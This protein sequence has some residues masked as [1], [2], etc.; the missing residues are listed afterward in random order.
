MLL[1]PST[2]W[3]L[4]S[5]WCRRHY[6]TTPGRQRSSEQIPAAYSAIIVPHQTQTHNRRTK[7]HQE[8][9]SWLVLTAGK[10]MAMVVVDKEDYADKVLFLLADT[11]TYSIINKDPTTN[12]KRNLHRHLGATNEWDGSVTTATGKCIPLV[13]SP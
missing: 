10:G 11:S 6:Q 4:M 13:L 5:Q 1:C 9:Q 2:P 7:E 3:S 12:L 8:D